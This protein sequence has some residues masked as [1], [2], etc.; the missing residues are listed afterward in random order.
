MTVTD[1]G[2]SVLFHSGCIQIAELQ[3]TGDFGRVLI[4][5]PT[6]VAEWRPRRWNGIE[7]IRPEFRND[8]DRI[9][10]K[11]GIDRFTIKKRA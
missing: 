7:S 2:V 5:N 6:C 3:F 1:K 8:F 10:S 11:W 9:I 4:V